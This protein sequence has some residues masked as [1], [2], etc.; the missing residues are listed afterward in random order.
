VLTVR[1][2]LTDRML[3]FEKRPLRR[4]LALYAA[5][6]G[7]RRLHRARQLRPPRPA[8]IPPAGACTAAG[9]GAS[10]MAAVGGFSVFDGTSPRVTNAYPSAIWPPTSQPTCS[11]WISPMNPNTPPMKQCTAADTD[12]VVGDLFTV[13]PQLQ[14]DVTDRKS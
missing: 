13:A 3:I 4:E 5:H 7:A 10:S 6:Y 8:D 2:E 12:G 11:A 9:C 14:K 1:A